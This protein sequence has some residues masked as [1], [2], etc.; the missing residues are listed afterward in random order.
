MFKT[1]FGWSRELF[2]K[3][4]VIILIR[5]SI[6]QKNLSF[7]QTSAISLVLQNVGASQ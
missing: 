5:N 6:M 2:P 7:T 4:R 3:I 1:A